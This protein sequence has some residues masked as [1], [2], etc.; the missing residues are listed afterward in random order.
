M[1]RSMQRSGGGSTL[2]DVLAEHISQNFHRF[3]VSV[4]IVMTTNDATMYL[5]VWL[6]GV[7][8]MG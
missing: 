8:R 4:R 2:P 5:R 1:T 3:T 7:L 6:T